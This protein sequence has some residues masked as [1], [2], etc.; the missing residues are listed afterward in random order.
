MSTPEFGTK[1]Y[2]TAL[3]VDK[4][5][6]L[7]E[8][9]AN[10]TPHTILEMGHEIPLTA[11]SSRTRVVQVAKLALEHNWIVKVGSSKY[12]TGDKYIQSTGEVKPGHE[13][14]WLWAQGR[15]DNH[16]FEY[17]AN[18]CKL[19]GET[20]SYIDLKIGIENA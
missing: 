19:D 4:A 8:V 13:E 6:A 7:A 18:T 15:K 16:S 20:V 12:R 5:D 17:S 9:K 2:F 3:K 10:L 14:T 11:A 1:E